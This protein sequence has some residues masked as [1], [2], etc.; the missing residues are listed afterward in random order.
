VNL[1]R[2]ETGFGPHV[3]LADGSR[4]YAIDAAL[5]RSIDDAAGDAAATQDLLSRYGLL[6]AEPAIGPA[7][8]ADPPLQSLSLAVAQRCNLAC[9]YCYAQGGAFGGEAK[10]MPWEVAQS[11][12]RLLIEGATPGERVTLAFLGGEPMTNRTVVRRAT[13]YAAEQAGRRG[14]RIGFAITTNATLLREDDAA[15]FAQYSFAVTV[16]LDGI[17]AVHDTLRPFKGGQGSYARAMERLRPLLAARPGVKIFVRATVTPRNLRL[18]ETLEG[19]A[20]A[21]FDSIGFSPMLA[22]PDGGEALGEHD[23]AVLLEQMIDCG[24][25]FERHILAGRDHPF[26]NMHTAMWEIHRGTHRPYPCGA[27]AGYFGVSAD[28][29]LAACHRFV[30]DPAGAMGS[31]ASGID[32]T[33]QGA[34]LTTRFVDRQEPC[35]RCWARYLCGGGCHHEVIHRGRPACD[36]IR[37]WLHY[38]LQ[39]YVA[40]LEGRPDYF[41]AP[42]G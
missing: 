1:H 16:S 35:R 7:P 29:D 18:R 42:R 33:A 31:I 37:G 6:A 2:F 17:A 40:I 23:L 24:R 9:G 30:D 14:V 11:A 15:F 20:E 28:G 19:L 38:C 10:A 41:A 22:G 32:R 4:I 34:W 27:G 26:S 13:E 21:G 39:A 3:F 5:A 36:L 25:T 12:V 8:L